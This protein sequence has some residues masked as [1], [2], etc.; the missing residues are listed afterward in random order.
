M[1]T[2]NS[3]ITPPMRFRIEE[4]RLVFRKSTEVIK[5]SD[6]SYF[7]GQMGAGKSSIA[8]LIFYC[9]G[10]ELDFSPALQSEFVSAFLDI[11]INETPLTVERAREADQVHASWTRSN[12]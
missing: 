7:Y 6:I 1:G 3:N 10:G 4:L 8:R 12:E 11:T 2:R 9:L 5:F